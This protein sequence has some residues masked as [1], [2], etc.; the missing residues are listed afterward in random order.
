[1]NLSNSQLYFSP[2]LAVDEWGGEWGGRDQAEE[3][4]SQLGSSG[5]AS[6]WSEE[7]RSEPGSGARVPFP[8]YWESPYQSAVR[9][10]PNGASGLDAFSLRQGIW[11]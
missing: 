3:D 8:R 9:L 4:A 11:A 7:P 10:A 5:E 6:G 1:M 2:S